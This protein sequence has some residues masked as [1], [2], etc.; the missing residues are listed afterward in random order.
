MAAILLLVLCVTLWLLATGH[1]S[2][3]VLFVVLLLFLMGHL[4]NCNHPFGQQG[5]GYFAFICLLSVM[6]C[7]LFLL[8]SLVDY[9]L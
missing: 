1:I 6:V 9:V 2:C 8:M 4:W 7:L 5:T 3:L